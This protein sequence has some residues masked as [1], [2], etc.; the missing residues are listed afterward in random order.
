MN[1]TPKNGGAAFPG[2][3][4]TNGYGNQTMQTAPNGDTIWITHSPGMS[5]R[6][7]IATKAM[8]ALILNR[9]PEVNGMGEIL[10]TEWRPV[11][12]GAVKIADE[13]LRELEK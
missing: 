10:P 11:V 3:E 7:Y 13:M 6:A 1:E 4:G 12:S 2:I 9:E 8:Q 5:L